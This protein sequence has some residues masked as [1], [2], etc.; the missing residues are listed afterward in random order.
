MSFTKDTKKSLINSSLTLGI[1]YGNNIIHHKM[2]KGYLII[3]AVT[4]DDHGIKVIKCQVA[5]MVPLRLA[6]VTT[7]PEFRFL[8]SRLYYEYSF[9][10][11]I[12]L[13]LPLLEAFLNLQ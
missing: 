10:I 2:R 5:I 7:Y 8:T 4:I 11:L 3:D 1:N 12:H 9:N 13:V 6:T